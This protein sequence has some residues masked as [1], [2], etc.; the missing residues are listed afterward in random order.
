MSR[1]Y[2]KEL[3]P[4]ERIDDQVFLI[5][6]KD[7]RTTTQGGLYIHAILGD[8]TGQIPARVWQASESMYAAMPEGGFL[9]FKGRTESYKGALQF[10]IEA[11]RPV[12][13]T[14][15]AAQARPR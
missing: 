15:A 12:D 14:T 11:M 4:G 7:L 6:S 8:R 13:P 1:R 2:I 10:I 3:G 5:A 9:R